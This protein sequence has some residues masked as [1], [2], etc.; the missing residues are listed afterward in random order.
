MQRLYVF[1]H[2]NVWNA[3]I[4]RK[5]TWLTSVCFTRFKSLNKHFN[6]FQSRLS[7]QGPLCV[8]ARETRLLTDKSQYGLMVSG[9]YEDACSHSVE[10]K[11]GNQMEGKSHGR[12]N[13]AT[14][15][16]SEPIDPFPLTV[17]AFTDRQWLHG[18]LSSTSLLLF[19]PSRAGAGDGWA[20]EERRCVSSG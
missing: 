12:R 2:H 16:V 14:A 5:A 9:P 7:A 3:T 15:K 4:K 6:L 18:S 13:G 8:Y 11:E 1:S 19:H 20:E 10:E 17:L